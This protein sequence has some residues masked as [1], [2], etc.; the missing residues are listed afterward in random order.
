MDL[1]IFQSYIYHGMK[2]DKTKINNKL[3]KTK[4]MIRRNGFNLNFD[5]LM[6]RYEK[7]MKDFNKSDWDKKTYES[8]DGNYKYTTYVKVFDL[9]DMDDSKEMS[10]EEFLKIK[11]ER[12]IENE[13]FESAVRLRDQIKNLETNKEVIEK[14]ELE[15]KKSIEEQNF[16]LSIELRDKL[17]NLRS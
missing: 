15:L 14:L 3:L 1:L 2:L 7:M 16:E 9:S 6:A 13:D 4:D 8:P 11:L 12:A 5:D 10:K 17:K